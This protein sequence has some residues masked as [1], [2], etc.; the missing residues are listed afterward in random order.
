MY[1]KVKNK[2]IIARARAFF[3]EHTYFDDRNNLV[4]KIFRI[5]MGD[6]HIHR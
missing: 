2:L 1:F 3:Q 4:A 6:I 5:E